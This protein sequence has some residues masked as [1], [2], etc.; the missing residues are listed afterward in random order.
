MK[1]IIL[2]VSDADFDAIKKKLVY[3]G[4]TKGIVLDVTEALFSESPKFE[5]KSLKGELC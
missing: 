5:L 4:T 2:K 3:E 1:D